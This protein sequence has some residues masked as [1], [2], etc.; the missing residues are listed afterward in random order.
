MKPEQLAERSGL[1]QIG[2]RSVLT[3]EPLSIGALQRSQCLLRLLYGLD[4]AFY[5]EPSVF[6][7][8]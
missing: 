1:A 5:F 8:K 2:R 6:P 4:G 7:E 3:F